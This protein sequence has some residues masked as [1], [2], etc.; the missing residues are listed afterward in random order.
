MGITPI[1]TGLD[2]HAK[3]QKI[4]VNMSMWDNKKLYGERQHQYTIL[5]QH[6]KDLAGSVIR[7]S[8]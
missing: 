3:V 8:C 4:C 2:P 5:F 6:V 1:N 7:C